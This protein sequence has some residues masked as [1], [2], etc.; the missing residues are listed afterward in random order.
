MIFFYNPPNPP[1]MI[2]SPLGLIRRL[3]T[4]RV[5]LFPVLKRRPSRTAGTGR[6]G[7]GLVLIAIVG[8]EGTG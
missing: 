6:V 4:G 3:T 5:P 8:I 1:R 2:R 7:E